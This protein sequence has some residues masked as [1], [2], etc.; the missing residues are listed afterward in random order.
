MTDWRESGDVTPELGLVLKAMARALCGRLPNPDLLGKIAPQYRD[1][2]P[3][4]QVTIEHKPRPPK[5][6]RPRLKAVYT[7][8]IIGDRV[9]G[10]W[11]FTPGQLAKLLSK[12]S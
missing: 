1:V 4:H 9:V 8:S 3:G 11:G 7:I 12:V 10:K 5:G 6:T 2:V